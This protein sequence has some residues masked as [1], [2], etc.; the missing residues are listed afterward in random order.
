MS[1]SLIWAWKGDHVDGK[2]GVPWQRSQWKG[3]GQAGEE[4]ALS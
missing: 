1:T 3:G 4:R 2:V